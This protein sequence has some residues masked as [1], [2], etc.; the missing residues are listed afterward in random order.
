MLHTKH[1]VQHGVDNKD[2][3][4]RAK[5]K[6]LVISVLMIL[7]NPCNNTSNRSSRLHENTAE[8]GIIKASQSSHNKALRDMETDRFLPFPTGP[9]NTLLSKG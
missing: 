6:L 3:M 7:F 2:C 4:M 8:L 5:T 9:P 1:S